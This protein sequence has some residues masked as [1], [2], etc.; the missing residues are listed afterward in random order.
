M[1][2]YDVAERTVTKLEQNFGTTTT[3]KKDPQDPRFVPLLP[4]G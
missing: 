2:M 1:Y 4:I 3:K